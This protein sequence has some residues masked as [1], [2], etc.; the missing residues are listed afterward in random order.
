[1]ECCND[2]GVQG[3]DEGLSMEKIMGILREILNLWCF[4]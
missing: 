4:Y 3:S 1:V 2:I